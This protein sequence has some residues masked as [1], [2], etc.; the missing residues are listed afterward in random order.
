MMGAYMNKRQNPNS[1]LLVA[2]PFILFI[3]LLCFWGY[4]SEKHQKGEQLV[5]VQIVQVIPAGVAVERTDTHERGIVEG[6]L[7]SPGDQFNIKA[8]YILI[9]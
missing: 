6:H 2:L 9:P 5:Q 4:S 7:G 3:A 1:G 8:K